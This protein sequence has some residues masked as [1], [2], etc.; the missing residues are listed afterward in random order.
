MQNKKITVSKLKEQFHLNQVTG[1]DTSLN[2]RI[3]IAEISRPGFELAG[4]FQHSDL[5]RV[6]VFGEKEIAFIQSL[7]KKIQAERFELLTQDLTPAIIICR[8]FDCPTV[9]KRIAKKKNFPI[10]LTENA[11]GRTSIDVTS[12]LDEQLAEETLM[13][14][15]FLSIHGKGVIIKGDSGIGKSEIALDLIQRGHILIADD[16]VELSHV[17]NTIVG[18]SP[19]VLSN[20]LEI[21]G[22]G[23]IDVV[24]MFGVSS[25]LD[26]DVVDLVVHLER[27]VP[28]KEYTRIGTESV[29]LFENILGVEVPKVIVPVTGGRS[30]SA[31]IEAAVMNMRLKELGYDSTEEFVNRIIANINKNK[32]EE[33]V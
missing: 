26:K 19:E 24:K 29:E 2:R 3:E 4:F 13:H 14:G 18:K 16:C 21:R 23:V 31:I 8:G 7:D 5:R 20:L 28:S 25:V 1:D 32:S 15:V 30:M 11:T 22:I 27:W 10:F 6:I 17:G 33:G 12:Y 9:L